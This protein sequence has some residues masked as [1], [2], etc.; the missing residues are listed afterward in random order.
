MKT[1]GKLLLSVLAAIAIAVA[2][3]PAAAQKLPPQR[4]QEKEKFPSMQ[5]VF[6]QLPPDMQ[7][8][9]MDEMETVRTECQQNSVIS[10]YQDCDCRAVK[11]LDARLAAGPEPSTNQLAYQVSMECPNKPAIAGHEY[12]SCL[13]NF[14]HLI[15]DSPQDLEKFCKCTANSVAQEY[16]LAPADSLM[17]QTRLTVAAYNKCYRICPAQRIEIPKKTGCGTGNPA[18]TRRR[19]LRTGWA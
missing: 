6:E 8:E 10:V 11:F 16:A 4:Q 7:Q 17:Y 9:L 3:M 19:G 15:N 18:L 5:H 2:A 14:K 12:K 13:Q 1:S